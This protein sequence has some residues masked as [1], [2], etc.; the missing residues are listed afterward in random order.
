MNA[1]K[2]YSPISPNI[3]KNISSFAS[4]IKRIKTTNIITVI[5]VKKKNIALFCSFLR[6]NSFEIN[7]SHS[8]LVNF[9][10]AIK[11]FFSRAFSM[12]LLLLKNI[13]VI[14]LE[15]IER[16]KDKTIP[17]YLKSLASIKV[18]NINNSIIKKIVKIKK[19][20]YIAFCLF[21]IIYNRHPF[22]FEKIIAYLL[23]LY[24]FSKYRRKIG[25]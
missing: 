21:F 7:P 20:L 9:H 22:Y 3:T 1:I 15:T 8:S 18:I 11:S 17:A 16:K 10:L 12:I 13:K 14:M 25:K 6:M 19:L 24:L 2:A 23:S 5:I 4:S